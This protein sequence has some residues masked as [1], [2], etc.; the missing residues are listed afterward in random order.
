MWEGWNIFVFKLPNT[1][2]QVGYQPFRYPDCSEILPS[3][4]SASALVADLRVARRQKH[5][6]LGACS[7]VKMKLVSTRE[8]LRKALGR[9][10]SPCRHPFVD[11]EVSLDG[12]V[13]RGHIRRT[14]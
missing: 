1:G 2:I 9:I 8:L 6:V 7:L 3:Y 14:R 12:G 4:V 13:D 5:F 11:R 10:A